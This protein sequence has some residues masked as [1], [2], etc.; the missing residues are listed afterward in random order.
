MN[1]GMFSSEGNVAVCGIDQYALDH[2]LPWGVVYSNLVALSVF[3][4]KYA[5]AIDT[6]VREAVYYA[7]GAN[8]RGEDFYV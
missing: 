6:E 8:E 4:K 1:Y 5:E 2:N 3:D 7:I